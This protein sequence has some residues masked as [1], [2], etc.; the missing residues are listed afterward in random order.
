MRNYLAPLGVYI[1]RTGHTLP[2]DFI[3]KPQGT[4]NKLKKKEYFFDNPF[5]TNVAN[6]F[7]L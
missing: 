6:L 5:R 1:N 4:V 3:P 2:D 7:K